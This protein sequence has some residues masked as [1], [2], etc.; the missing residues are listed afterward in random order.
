MTDAALFIHPKKWRDTCDLF[1]LPF[2]TFRPTEIMGY[3]HAGNDVFHVRGIY[4]G[5][6][7][8]AYVKA[9]RQEGA[10]IRNEVAI[11]RQ[12]DLPCVPGVIDAGFDSVPFV[13]TEEMPGRRLSVIV[14][15]SNACPLSYMEEYGEMLG[16]IHTLKPD[17]APVSDRKFFHLPP[18]ETLEKT[19]L[20][21]LRAYFADRPVGG[22]TV[23]C[24]GDFHYANILW[25]EHHISGVLD[26]ELSGYG[27]RDFDIAWALILRPGQKFLKT[28]E[29]RE[30]FLKGYRRYGGYNAHAVQYYMAQIY[31]WFLQFSGNDTAYAAYVREWLS[32]FR[33][34]ARSRSKS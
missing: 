14:E 4:E 1:A 6:E 3:P 24:H 18:D 27:D 17:A 26:F 28:R 31:V 15:E 30:R 16:Y 32:N 25:K 22:T 29:E 7:I 2:H 12:L 33:E 9:A 13:V 34:I 8:A 23:F 20:S 19:E 5:R 11:L 10:A 21:F